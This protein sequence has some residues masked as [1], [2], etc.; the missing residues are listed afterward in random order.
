MSNIDI[1]SHPKYY[2]VYISGPQDNLKLYTK[3]LV[4]GRSI[5]G[6]R[7]LDFRGIEY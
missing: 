2:D 3:N 1:R 5:Y 7:L 4:P 6:E